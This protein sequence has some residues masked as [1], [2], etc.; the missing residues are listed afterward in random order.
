[1]KKISVALIVLTLLL[2]GCNVPF[3]GKSPEDVSVT[4]ADA[5]SSESA[6]KSSQQVS[7]PQPTT[8]APSTDDGTIYLQ[9]LSAGNVALC[10]KIV[11]ANLKK[12]CQKKLTPAAK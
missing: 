1:M 7:Q 3:M 2:S 5:Q 8:E 9:A 12:D 4:D 6:Q 11:D 10:A